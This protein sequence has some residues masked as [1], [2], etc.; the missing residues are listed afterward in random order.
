M[1]LIKL[2]FIGA[3]CALAGCSSAP[4]LWGPEPSKFNPVLVVHGENLSVRNSYATKIC[5]QLDPKFVAVVSPSPIPIDPE[6]EVSQGFVCDLRPQE[7]MTPLQLRLIQSRTF[8]V[9]RTDLRRA[10]NS[11]HEDMSG[12]CI[13]QEQDKRLG[14]EGEVFKLY[15]KTPPYLHRYEITPFGE[16]G[17]LL[18]AR[19]IKSMN[20]SLSED[21]Q[22]TET[23]PYNEFFLRLSGQIF[24][25]AIELNPKEIR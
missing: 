1:K 13:S 16:K 6:A 9:E 17:S 2:S 10:I 22:L 21:V 15:C 19:I 3:L 11:Y 12:N 4:K 8:R 23:E 5:R 20:H 24:V 14:S 7:K 18:R 25:D